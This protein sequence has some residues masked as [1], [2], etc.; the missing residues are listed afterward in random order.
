ME[1]IELVNAYRH[2]PI[3][4]KKEELARLLYDDIRDYLHQKFSAKLLPSM[5]EDALQIS[6]IA[7]FNNLEKFRGQTSENFRA[8][9]NTIFLGKRND[10]FRQFYRTKIQTLPPDELR[11]QIEK[12][13]EIAP[14]SPSERIENE[15]AVSFLAK[16]KPDCRQLLWKKAL[17]MKLREI[18]KEMSLN[19]SRVRMRIKRCV[20]AAFKCLS[21]KK[22]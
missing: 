16:L 9:C 8:W 17:G 4:H 10:L 1:V 21:R 13:W 19:S 12:S 5:V 7:I 18:A 14:P 3:L 2:E 20:E 6:L 22:L 15:E 11:L